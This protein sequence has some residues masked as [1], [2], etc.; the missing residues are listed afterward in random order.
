[1]IAW[2][3]AVAAR[4]EHPG[5][6]SMRASADAYVDY[7]RAF[8]EAQARKEG[9]TLDEV[10]ELT[11][12]GVMA[13]RSSQPVLIEHITGRTLG[14]G[15]REQLERLLERA[16]ADVKT[17]LRAQVEAD[18]PASDR[19]AAIRDFEHEWMAE[20]SQR[21]GLTDAQFDAMLAPESEGPF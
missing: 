21:F 18:A 15:E 9:L 4:D 6:R 14:A 7:N 2:R 11:F 17:T 5:E 16:N 12:F 10:R 1:V 19:Q 8:A 3:A 20:L 13:L